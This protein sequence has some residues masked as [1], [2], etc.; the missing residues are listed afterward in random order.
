M[1]VQAA[2]HLGRHPGPLGVFFRRK[3]KHKNRNV[4]VVATARKLVVI[5]W[6]MLSKNEPYRYA[7]PRSTET[8]LQR[9]RVAATGK[10]KRG[11]T[12]GT[13]RP[14]NYGSGQQTRYI[15][16]IDE[17]YTREG[18]PELPE[19]STGEKRVLD[20]LGLTDHVNSLHHSHRVER[21]RRDS[22]AS[23]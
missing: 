12:K 14:D 7:Q 4:A 23:K 17:V 19:L 20:E 8:K 15:P 22:E 16:S 1:M 2:Q 3:A 18:L 13:K 10:R 21:K 9:L 5:A 6:H 11:S